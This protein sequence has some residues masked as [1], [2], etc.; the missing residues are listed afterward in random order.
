MKKV[1]KT[2]KV[3][4]PAEW[5]AEAVDFMPV[6][7]EKWYAPEILNYALQAQDFIFRTMTQ[8]ELRPKRS[9]AR[10]LAKEKGKK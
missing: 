8:M 10:R 6:E 3:M 1:L 7:L 4:T 9:F 2:E 5:E